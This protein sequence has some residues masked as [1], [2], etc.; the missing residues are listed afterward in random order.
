MQVS[1][2]AKKVNLKHVV[3]LGVNTRKIQLRIKLTCKQGV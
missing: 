3:K 2:D 1:Q